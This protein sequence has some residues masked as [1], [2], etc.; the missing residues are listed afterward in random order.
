MRLYFF[1]AFT[2][3]Y[4]ITLLTSLFFMFVVVL[5][6]FSTTMFF[7]MFFLYT[8][9]LPDYDLREKKKI[10]WFNQKCTFSGNC[11]VRK[12]VQELHMVIECNSIVKCNKQELIQVP[13]FPQRV[14]QGECRSQVTGMPVKVISNN[15]RQDNR[16]VEEGHNS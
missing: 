9:T 7:L 5:R 3:F 1:S 13:H 11:Q 14:G 4:L 8:L 12:F 6:S 2:F 10:I 15:H 16:D